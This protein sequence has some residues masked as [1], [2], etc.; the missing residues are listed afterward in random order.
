MTWPG[1]LTVAPFGTGATQLVVMRDVARSAGTPP[2]RTFIE[3][4]VAG[5]VIVAHGT[6][7]GEPGVGTFGHPGMIGVP[8]M[9]VIRSAGAPPTFTRTCFGTGFAT[10]P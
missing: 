2:I 4:F 7:E 8:G 1:D 5:A 9:S 6:N 10:P 3:P